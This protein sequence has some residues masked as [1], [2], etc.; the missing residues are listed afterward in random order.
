M[1]IPGRW[2]AV[3]IFVLSSSLNYLDRQLFSA[4]A[5]VIRGEFG[6]TY[7]DYGRVVSYF[8]L[9]Y[10]IAAPLMGLVIDRIGLNAGVSLAVGVWSLATVWTGWAKDLGGLIASRFLLGAAQGGG[11]PA[12]GKA[13]S[14]YLEPRERALGQ[15]LS[16]VGLSIGMIAAPLLAGF[17]E[18][19]FGWRSAFLVGG[20]LGLVWVPLWLFVARR[21]PRQVL[22]PGRRKF[23]VTEMLRS[24]GYWGLVVATMLVMTVYSLWSNWTTPYLVKAWGMQADVVN[25][26]LAWIPPLI[27]ALGGIFGGAASMR[28]PGEVADA[29]RRAVLYGGLAVAAATALVPF[30]GSPLFAA[31]CIGISYS[32]A[33]MMSVN[34]YALPLDL[35]GVERA[36]FGAASLTGAYGLMQTVISPA[37]GYVVDVHGFAPV[38]LA[39]AMLPLLGV[40][41]LYLTRERG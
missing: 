25:R 40:G 22:D 15:G 37:I 2:V 39:V 34:L 23:A 12:A 28:M 33:T 10:A 8:S 41:S 32:C 6:W 9:V 38:C 26:T 3:G 29:R 4:L 24:R 20:A 17:M 27:G 21:A 36:A 19:R 14:T 11:V 7:E 31:L 1:R 35:F 18:P 13:M 30:V 16:Q 5:P